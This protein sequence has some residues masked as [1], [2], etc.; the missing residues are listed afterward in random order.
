M[1]SSLSS[2]VRLAVYFDFFK[3]GRE[4]SKFSSLAHLCLGDGLVSDCLVCCGVVGSAAP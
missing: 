3:T 1:T 4:K 2:G